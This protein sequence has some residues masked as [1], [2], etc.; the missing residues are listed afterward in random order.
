MTDKPTNQTMTGKVAV[1]VTEA[2]RLPFADYAG[3]EIITATLRSPDLIRRFMEVLSMAWSSKA[4]A[5]MA[6]YRIGP[7]TDLERWCDPVA[8]PEG[9]LTNMAYYPEGYLSD[10]K[11]VER[12]QDDV[13]SLIAELFDALGEVAPEGCGFGAHEGDGSCFGFWVYEQDEFDVEPSSD[14]AD[15]TWEDPKGV[16][17]V[18]AVIADGEEMDFGDTKRD[19]LMD[20]ARDGA[21]EERREREGSDEMEQ[22][23]EYWHS[24]PEPPEGPPEEGPG[25]FIAPEDAG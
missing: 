16:V 20:E 25:W 10:E 5:I 11:A 1:V 21:A 17:T 14:P 3:T 6:D 9:G 22:D 15:V 12:R 2:K 7:A 23:E 8:R 19:D 18:D 13:G 4:E 24:A